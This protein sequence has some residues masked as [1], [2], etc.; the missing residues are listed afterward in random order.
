MIVGGILIALYIL[1]GVSGAV[2]M[3]K[4]SLKYGVIFPK[5][6]KLICNGIIVIIFCLLIVSLYVLKSVTG[7]AILF[8]VLQV[9]LL[10]STPFFLYKC[11]KEQKECKSKQTY[12]SDI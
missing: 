7:I 2:F 6:I 11:N 10:L 1:I 4:C 5:N 12:V 3:R 8:D 9:L